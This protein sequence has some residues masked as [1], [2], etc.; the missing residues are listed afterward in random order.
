[1]ETAWPWPQVGHLQKGA[2]DRQPSFVDLHPMRTLMGWCSR[3]MLLLLLGTSAGCGRS[4]SDDRR[5]ARDETSRLPPQSQDPR[6]ASTNLQPTP[7]QPLAA[8]P[9][10]E[11]SAAEFFKQGLI[12]HFRIQIDESALNQL[13]REPRTFVR[14]DV[15]VDDVIYRNVGLHLKGRRGSFRRL[16]SKPGLTLKFNKF[17]QGQRFHGLEKIHL[18]NEVQ[19]PSFM[20]EILCSQM[21]REAGVPAARA[22]NAR[23]EMNSRKLGFYVLVEGVTEEFLGLY[24]ENSGGNLYDFPYTHDITSSDAKESKD[25]DASDLRALAAACKEPDL[26]KRWQR[27]DRVLDLDR[28]ITFLALEVMIW[29]WDSYAMCRNNYRVYHDPTSDQIVFIPHGMDQIFDNPQGSVWPVMKGLVAR[30]VLEIP[31]GRRRYFERMEVLADRQFT[32]ALMTAR[33]TGLRNR[34]RPVL[35]DLNPR[36]AK[37]HD[38]AVARLEERIQQRTASVQKQLTHPP[39]EPVASSHFPGFSGW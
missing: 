22:T 8:G 16:D 38:Q 29:D 32:S 4:S 17:E 11:L 1:M 19:D 2:D 35:L 28:F 12:P 18:N 30:A 26:A 6:L 33:V 10:K 31:E 3:L 7:T 5:P 34:I 21:F 9:A 27:L 37:K 24:F 13:S 15:Q 20:T 36:A 25:R 39:T 23:V 14:A